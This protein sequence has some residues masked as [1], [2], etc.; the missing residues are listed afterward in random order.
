M[1]V[2]G[3]VYAELKTKILG[4]KYD[5]S[6]VF[7]TPSAIQKLNAVYRGKDYVPNVLSFPLTPTVG[8]I[9]ICKSVAKKEAA[10]YGH[11]ADE[12][13]YYLFI[14]GCLHLK[15]LPHGKEMDRL[16]KKYMKQCA[17][18]CSTIEA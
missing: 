3:S 16:E 6:L 11:T 17:Q 5:L 2:A 14:H 15:G 18:L 1:T 10:A 8:E 13:I 9:H 4:K 7:S 12:H